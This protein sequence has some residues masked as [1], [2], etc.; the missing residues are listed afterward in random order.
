VTIF[1]RI[2]NIIKAGVDRQLYYDR[3][4]D[5]TLKTAKAR[6]KRKSRNGM[7]KA[8]RRRNRI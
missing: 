5:N 4:Q 1:Q 6:K 7:A 2:A 8:S 3:A